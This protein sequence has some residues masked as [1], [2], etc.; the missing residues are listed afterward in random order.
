MNTV[1]KQVAGLDVSKKEF[2]A[3]FKE[4]QE[5]GK[6]T[7]KGARKFAN[8]VSG[9]NQYLTWCSKRRKT[10]LVHVMEATGVYHEELCYF[11][12]QHAEQVSVQL[13][14]KVKYFIKSL[15]LKTK[16]DRSDAMAIAQMG[17]LRTLELW[18]P[19]SE[20]FKQI[21]DMCRTLAKLN[22][23]STAAASQLHAM[24]TSHSTLGESIQV[25][26]KLKDTYDNL[27]DECQKK[28]LEMVKQ[29]KQLY[30]RIEK[31]TAIKGV[32]TL[33]VVKL[34]AETDGFRNS[35]SIRKL[36][37]YAGLDVVHKQSGQYVGASR[38]SKKG[39]AYIRAALYM[40]ALSAKKHDQRLK[41]FY[42]R[43][44]K[45]LPKKKQAIVAVMRKILI[46]VYTLWKNG[47]SY[48]PK[49]QWNEKAGRTPLRIA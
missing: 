23:G 13:P 42:E 38:I 19:L 12:Y 40:P 21:R 37:S 10:T 18:Q 9:F 29:D 6:I 24:K 45:R 7:I 25:L 26:E 39:N 2:E 48:D 16:T 20:G 8:N 47:Q 49:H 33:T 44:E 34:L 1:K 32:G 35:S 31:I 11:L 15:N 36:V 28:I 3:C 14:Q 27:I 43:L 30:Q 5:N 46:L 22:K 41:S 4:L 17:I